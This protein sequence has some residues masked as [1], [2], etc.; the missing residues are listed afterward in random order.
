MITLLPYSFGPPA[1]ELEGKKTIQFC[2]NRF[3]FQIFQCFKPA[4]NKYTINNTLPAEFLN[5]S[6]H[7]PPHLIPVV[8]SILNTLLVVCS[9]ES[10]DLSSNRSNAPCVRA[11]GSA[12]VMALLRRLSSRQTYPCTT[13]SPSLVCHTAIPEN[14]TGYYYLISIVII[15]VFLLVALFRP[16]VSKI[17]PSCSSDSRRD[18]RR[19]R[20]SAAEYSTALLYPL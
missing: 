14:I 9:V 2:M 19:R 10:F 17:T 15:Q 12:G 13:S 3:F 4:G 1:C 16:C 20:R 18:R 11:R 7:P 6:A 8:L 5:H